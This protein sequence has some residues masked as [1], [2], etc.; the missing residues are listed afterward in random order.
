MVVAMLRGQFRRWSAELT[1]DE[2][3]LSASSLAV[4]LDTRSVDTGNADRDGSLR[5][6]SFFDVDRFPEATFRSRRVEQVGSA[7]RIVGDL[8]LRGVTNEIVLGAELGGF[9][10]DP[11]GMRRAGF[12]AHASIDRAAFGM[13]FNQAL[14]AGGVAIGERVDVSMDIEVVSKSAA[15]ASDSASDPARDPRAIAQAREQV[16]ALQKM[17]AETAEARARRQKEKP[18]YERLGGRGP[19]HAVVTDIVEMHFTE[20]LTA[21]LTKGVDKAKLVQHVVDW[22]CRAAGGP[23][24]YTGRDMVTAHQHLHMTDVHFMVAGDQ[25]LRALTK[26]GVPEP[27]K[28][29]VLCAIVA[30]HDDVVR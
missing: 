22:L 7:L 4:T 25:I 3:D 19:I 6:P 10:V 28:Q 16:V 18:L 2:N 9:V 15:T 24:T 11:R 12:T 8:T 29:E 14:E 5:S 30:H 20:P 23:E 21:P 17:L 26:H 1:M 13:V 27:E